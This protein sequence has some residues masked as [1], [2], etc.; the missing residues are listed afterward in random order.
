[1][2]KSQRVELVHLCNKESY[3]LEMD[4]TPAIDVLL[5]NAFRNDLDEGYYLLIDHSLLAV[6][7]LLHATLNDNTK[8]KYVGVLVEQFKNTAYVGGERKGLIQTGLL[9]CLQVIF[10][11]TM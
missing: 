7:T 6:M 10:V 9:S 8:L 5:K 2:K 11:L 4:L 1:M 3:L